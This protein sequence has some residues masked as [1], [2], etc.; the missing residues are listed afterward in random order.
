MAQIVASLDAR[1]AARIREER[2]HRGWT[3]L[4]LAGRSGVSRAMI[5][6]VERGAVRPTAALLGRL[7][8]AFGLPLSLL[9]ARSEA[10]PSR[11][12]RRR[13]HQTWT[14]PAT[15]YR[16]RAVSPPGDR[17]LQL[18]VVDLP[19]G[20]RVRYPADA[21]AFIHQQ[22]WVLRGVLTFVEGRET[23]TL[24]AGDCLQLGPPT[25][26]TFEN[27][28]SAACRYLVAVAPRP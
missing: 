3:V 16:R 21:Y 19:A 20:S 7:A 13:D 23:H 24:R 6:K 26:C 11:L 14:D 1:L 12:S 15:R 18:T 22:I 10:Q 25:P 17:A 2:E 8:A 4:E 27:R 9:L 28:T 5:A